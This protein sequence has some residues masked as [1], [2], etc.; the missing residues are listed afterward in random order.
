MYKSHVL[1][2][3]KA[4]PITSIPTYRTCSIDVSL[5]AESA[6][7]GHH[8]MHV[9]Y[10]LSFPYALPQTSCAARENGLA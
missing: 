6:L 3:L 5:L 2:V 4:V 1:A 8:L 9:L 7:I 10:P